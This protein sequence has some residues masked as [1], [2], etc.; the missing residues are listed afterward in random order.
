MKDTI[1]YI[2][3]K[4]STAKFKCLPLISIYFSAASLFFYDYWYILICL[5]FANSGVWVCCSSLCMWLG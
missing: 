5:E 1:A 4:M 2:L 3:H